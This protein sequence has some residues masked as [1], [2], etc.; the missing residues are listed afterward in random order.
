L[1]DKKFELPFYLSF[2]IDDEIFISN[3]KFQA[4]LEKNLFDIVKNNLDS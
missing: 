4:H 1:L 3:P 2:N